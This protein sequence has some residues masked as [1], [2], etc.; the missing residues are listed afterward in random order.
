MVPGIPD[1]RVVPAPI[2]QQLP[3]R[4]AGS[5]GVPGAPRPAHSGRI[6]WLITDSR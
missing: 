2:M 5:P 3:A 4:A 1:S 6:H